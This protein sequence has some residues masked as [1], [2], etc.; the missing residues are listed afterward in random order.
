LLRIKPQIAELWDGASSAATTI[1]ELA[2]AL[3]T[4]SQP[5]LGENRK[6]TVGM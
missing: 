5:A 1:F 2:K 6:V 3:L 4:E